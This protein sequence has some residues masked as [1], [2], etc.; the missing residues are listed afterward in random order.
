[1]GYVCAWWCI[2]VVDAVQGIE[3][4]INGIVWGVGDGKILSDF[5]NVVQGIENDMKS[6]E[7]DMREDIRWPKGPFKML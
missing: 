2:D 4:G 7:N 6:I 5:K 1:M 3:N